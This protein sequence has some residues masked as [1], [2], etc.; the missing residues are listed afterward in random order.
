MY[1]AFVDFMKAFDT[2]WR[3]GLWH[4]MSLHNINGKMYDVIFNM[5]CNI[6]SCIV[7]NN[8]KSNYFACD[9]RENLSPFLFSLFLNDLETFLQAK[10]VTGL[11][12]ISSDLENQLNIYLKLFI[13]LYADDT[14][15][16]SESESDLLVQ[17]DAFREYCLTW[18]LKVNIDKA[19]IVISGSESTPQNLSFKYNGSE[20]EAVNN[21][22]YLGIIFSKTSNFNLAKK[23]LVDG[24]QL[25]LCMKY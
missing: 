19:K 23:R 18:K 14:V 11:E 13:I 25:F 1:C 17:L 7:F 24:K 9:N 3:A 4:K 6:K 22:N 10:N 15:I 2:V 21:F 5:Y 12:S 20:I 16:L 8:C